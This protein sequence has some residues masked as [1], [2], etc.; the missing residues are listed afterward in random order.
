MYGKTIE[1]GDYLPA[2]AAVIDEA[3]NAIKN[4]VGSGSDIDVIVVAG[5]GAKLYVDAIRAKF[6][7]HE[8]VALSN[9]AFANVRGFQ[10]IGERMA[11]SA[12]RAIAG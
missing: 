11:Q 4:S 2:G 8:V 9:P 10:I 12:G 5:G 1:L 7:R 3:V 6:P